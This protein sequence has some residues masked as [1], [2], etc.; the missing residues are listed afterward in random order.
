MNTDVLVLDYSPNG[1][2]T[3]ERTK[4]QN[5]ALL[6][7][8][9][10]GTK[11]SREKVG[12]LLNHLAKIFGYA[13]W[14][15]TPWEK[16]RQPEL[17]ALKT[18]WEIEKKSPATINL[19]LSVLK[20]VARQAWMANLMTD[21]EFTVIQ[22]IKG[23]R[24]SRASKGRA[25][26]PIESSRLIVG[27]EMKSDAKGIRDA[28]II[29]LGIGCGLRRAEIASLKMSSLNSGDHQSILVMGKGNKE[30]TVYC[31]DAVWQRVT[32]WKSI[33]D[34]VDGVE[35]LF[36][37]VTKGGKVNSANSLT[38]DAIFK[39]LRSRAKEF[40]LE[41]FAPHDLRRTY[42]TRLFELGGDVNV[43]RQAMGHASILTTQRYDKRGEEALK[44]LSKRLSI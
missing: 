20:G 25:L 32:R 9:T 12:Q 16:I 34:K 3:T 44:Q 35:E 4:S 21:H 22:A 38:E 43:V 30:R 24:G 29:A 33:R 14:I 26:T 1:Q 39:I 11:Q 36:C 15:S 18:K 42:A 28:A 7:M 5:P 27:C 8:M 37:S 10:L 41:A 6:Y 13:D 2:L 23:A 19:A 17:L 31:S 40:G